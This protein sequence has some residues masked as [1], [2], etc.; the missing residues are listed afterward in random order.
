MAAVNGKQAQLFIGSQRFIKVSYLRNGQLQ[1]RIETVPV[2]V[3]LSVQP[4]TGGNKEITTNLHVEV[5][6]IVALDPSTG[7]PRLSTRE[8]DSTLRTND[9][10]TCNSSPSSARLATAKSLMR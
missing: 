2:G 8:A 5:S 7:V 9:G 6:N 1:E 3:R 10:D 4:W